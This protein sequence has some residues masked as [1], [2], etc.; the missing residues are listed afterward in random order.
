[1]ISN[2]TVSQ[3]K[4]FSETSEILKYIDSSKISKIPHQLLEF[5]EKNKDRDYIFDYDTEKSL[6]DQ[7]LNRNTL[8]LLAFLNFNTSKYW[9][10]YN[11]M[12]KKIIEEINELR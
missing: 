1:M 8:I 5:I 2:I 11:L 3:K 4:A 6:K 7:N 10:R 12:N 9:D